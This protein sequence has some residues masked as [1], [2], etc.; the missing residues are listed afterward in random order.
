M[1]EDRN[2]ALACVWL[3]DQGYE[4]FRNI[5]RRDTSNLVVMKDGVLRLVEVESVLDDRMACFT[6]PVKK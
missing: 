4:V 6:A 5:E 2:L 3:I 1:S